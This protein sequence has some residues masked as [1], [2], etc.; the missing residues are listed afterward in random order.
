MRIKLN[1]YGTFSF[2]CIT[3]FF[4]REHNRKISKAVSKTEILDI[5]HLT[6][7]NVLEAIFN[8]KLLYFLPFIGCLIQLLYGETPCNPSMA[9]LDL[10][11]FGKLGKAHKI[12]TMVDSTFASPYLQPAIQYGIDISMHSW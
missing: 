1:S 5:Y 7:Q 6:F 11:Q 4:V 2:V 9:I 10:E 12:L 8:F 3:L